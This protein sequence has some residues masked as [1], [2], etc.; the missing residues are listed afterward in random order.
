MVFRKTRKNSIPGHFGPKA[1]TEISVFILKILFLVSR[2]YLPR[3]I[4]CMRVWR[5]VLGADSGGIDVFWRR[6]ERWSPGSM[7][8]KNNWLGDMMS[9]DFVHV[10][11]RL[12]LTRCYCHFP[13]LY[14]VLRNVH[15]ILPNSTAI[16]SRFIYFAQF[17][18]VL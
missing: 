13:K 9:P 10:I 6:I 15:S 17:Y 7:S 11:F 16:F 8:P 5:L 1:S 2:L 14:P 18:P 4:V 12:I 3:R